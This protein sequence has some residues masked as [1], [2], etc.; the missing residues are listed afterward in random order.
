M[1]FISLFSRFIIVLRRVFFLAWLDVEYQF[2]VHI[3]I[4]TSTHVNVTV[5]IDVSM[6]VYT[7]VGALG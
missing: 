4:F 1:F 6:D 2:P 3:V 5:V 7:N